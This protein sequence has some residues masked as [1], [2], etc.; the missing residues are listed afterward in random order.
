MRPRLSGWFGELDIAISFW[1]QNTK[2]HFLNHREYWEVTNDQRNHQFLFSL[3]GFLSYFRLDF[4]NKKA[5][6]EFFQ[7]ELFN[8]F[9]QKLFLH[10]IF[11]GL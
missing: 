5:R 6:M 10:H 1:M 3:F 2:A 4:P 7:F 8:E 11:V 9:I